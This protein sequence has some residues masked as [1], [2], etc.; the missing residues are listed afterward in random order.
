MSN[1][2]KGAA[3]APRTSRSQEMADRCWRLVAAV[4]KSMHDDYKTLANKLSVLVRNCGLLQTL[5]F[6]YAKGKDHH[7]KMMQHIAEHLGRPIPENNGQAAEQLLGYVR[8]APAHEYRLMTARVLQA[9]DWHKRFIV[10]LCPDS[11]DE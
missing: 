10:G 2:Q 9:A 7:K 11:E 3:A 5:A 8:Q 4:P 1:T 6:F